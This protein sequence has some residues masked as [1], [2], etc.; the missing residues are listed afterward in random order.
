L[1]SS[2]AASPTTIDACGLPPLAIGTEDPILVVGLAAAH[3]EKLTKTVHTNNVLP[4]SEAYQI[5]TILKAPY[6]KFWTLR[7]AI[8]LQDQ[9]I[10]L[11]SRH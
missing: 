3:I 10:L 8:S 5:R 6:V 7:W 2:P 11:P 9:S 4:M 1:P